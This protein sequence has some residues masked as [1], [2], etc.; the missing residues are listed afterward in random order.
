MNEELRHWLD[1]EMQDYGVV[2]K[3]FN[4]RL[5]KK[6]PLWMALSV[7]G[8]VALGF[9]VGYDWTYVVR[10]HLPIGLGMAAFILLCFWI[11]TRSVSVK[12][13]RKLYERCL[14]GLSAGDQE[15]FALQASQFGRTWFLNPASDK[16]PARLLVGPDYWLYFRG[17][18]RVFRVADIQRLYAREETTRVG[19]SLGKTHVRQNLNIGV[20][21]VAEFREGTAAAAKSQSDHI[22]L[23]NS[24]QLEE[25]ESLIRRYCPKAGKLFEKE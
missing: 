5:M 11:Q 18:C 8:M 9:G 21:L 1:G 7:A 15:A 20:S 24:R 23:E 4:S 10:V 17:A 25:A 2:L 3:R 22:Y 13:V 16:Y 14:S 12:K 6:V 19:Y